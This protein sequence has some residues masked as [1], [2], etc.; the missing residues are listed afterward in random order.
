MPIFEC[1]RCNEMTYSAS[2]GAVTA[3]ER[4]G[5]EWQRVIEGDFDQAR[6][7][8]RTLGAGDH[9]TITY[10]DPAKVASFCARFVTDGINSGERV[11]TGLQPD[12]REAVAGLLEPE[13]ELAV[14][15]EHPRSI[16]GDFDADQGAAT[17]EEL[18]AD[19]G[20][21]TRILAGLDEESAE[22]VDPDELARYEAQAH[23]IIIRHGA[24]VVCVFDARSLPPEFLDVAGRYHGLEVGEDGGVRRSERF[25]YQ[26]V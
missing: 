7:R 17:Y 22:G 18:I 25:Q 12:L 24:I 10:D 15:W 21:T 6:R 9:A 2:M 19:E 16:Y 5:S 13:V 23:E 3:C 26:P 14:E 20:R 8:I 1:A 11:V 4:C